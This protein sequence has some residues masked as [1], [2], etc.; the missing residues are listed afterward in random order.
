MYHAL[1]TNRYLT[2]RV[3]P[4]IAVAAVALCVTLVIVVVSVMTGFLDM[5]KSSGRIL[6]GDVVVSVPVSGIPHYERLIARLD[7]LPQVAAAAPVVENLGLLRMP[8]PLGPDK[9]TEMVQFWGI[10][11]RFANVTGYAGTLHWKNVDDQ[12]W[13]RL[14]GAVLESHWEDLLKSMTNEQRIDLLLT[15]LSMDHREGEP[16]L[17]RELVRQHA[18]TYS[19]AHW[20][21]LMYAFEGH[22]QALQRVLNEDQWHMLMDSDPRLNDPDRILTD[23]LALSRDGRPGIALGIHVS[24]G[25]E[26]LTDGSYKPMLGGFW[27]M[28]AFDVTLT[29]IPVTGGGLET[30]P[31]SMILPVVNEFMS[32][33]YLIDDKRVMIPLA[34][35]QDMLHLNQGE[36]LDDPTDPMKVTGIE[37]ARATMV[38]V[39]A[40]EGVTP[41]E[42]RDIVAE[43]YDAFVD[44]VSRDES[45]VVQPPRPGPGVSIKTWVQQQAQFIGPVEKERELMRTLFSI[46]YLVCAALVLSIFWAIVYEK[47][48][49]IGILRSIGASRGGIVWIFLRYGLVVG[50]IGSLVGMGLAYLVVRNINSIHGALAEPPLALAVVVLL[51]AVGAV[52]LTVV[53]SWRGALLPLVLGS[54]ATLVLLAL[55]AGVLLLR[56]A[57]GVVIWDP[58]VYYFTVI[59]NQVDMTTAVSTIIGAIVFS[60]LGAVIPAAKAADTDPVAALRY[61]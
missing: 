59:P 15:A 14:F 21:G 28:P 61:E 40:A 20:S 16:A 2:S 55:G 37:P 57:G 45:A 54:L 5:V 8:Y 4:L 51:A 43:A 17:D 6:M 38:L 22:P 41:D 18:R 1:L 48:R 11:E 13:T 29:T 3:I 10:D 42:L 25:N 50:V 47:T 36:R 19:P 33:V 7:D 12:Q 60:L 30:Q 56:Q 32:G 24:E 35:A 27:W 49:D 9:Q 34:T 23:G 44:D 46:V 53:S 52:A 26:R 58:S 39:R 31:K